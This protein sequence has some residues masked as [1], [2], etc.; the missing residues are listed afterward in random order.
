[1]GYSTSLE[2]STL[3]VIVAVVAAPMLLCVLGALATDM[4]NRTTLHDLSVRV[5][6]LRIGMLRRAA[7]FGQL[8]EDDDPTLGKV[9]IIE[10]AP[11]PQ[12]A[13][14]A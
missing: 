3:V 11:Q 14:A 1:M 7:A 10:D 6:N 12:A 13:K 2:L 9:D 4:W 5:A 8:D